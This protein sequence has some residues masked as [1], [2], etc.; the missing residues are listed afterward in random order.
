MISSLHIRFKILGMGQRGRGE[1]KKEERL[2]L[3]LSEIFIFYKVWTSIATQA[4]V[5][6]AC[7]G[8]EKEEENP[9]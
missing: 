5:L 2:K 9:E 3:G 7:H 4:L 1:S 6:V 8:L